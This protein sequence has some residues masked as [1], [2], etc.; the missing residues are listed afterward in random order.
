MWFAEWQRHASARRTPIAP[1]QHE[2]DSV[3]TTRSAGLPFLNATKLLTAVCGAGR[4]VEAVE[5][6]VVEAAAGAE[7]GAAG[8]AAE[9]AEA[10]VAAAV[11]AEAAAAVVAEE[12]QRS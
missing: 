6:V 3:L 7:A 10:A 12:A 2:P 11:E 4:A 8:V 5:A 9:A 1:P